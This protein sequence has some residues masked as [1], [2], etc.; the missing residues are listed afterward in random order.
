MTLD[1]VNLMDAKFNLEIGNAFAQFTDGKEIIDYQTDSTG[2][3]LYIHK[4]Q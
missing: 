1:N 4:E 2:K 3:T